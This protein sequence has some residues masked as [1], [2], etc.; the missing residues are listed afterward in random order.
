MNTAETS[1]STLSPLHVHGLNLPFVCAVVQH[2]LLTEGEEWGGQW[3]GLL[4]ARSLAN[5][6]E[7]L[8]AP[9]QLCYSI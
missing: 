6:E 9:Y 5:A 4:R 1:H 7:K 8:T 2:D 3:S